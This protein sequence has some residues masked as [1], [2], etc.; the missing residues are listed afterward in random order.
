MV[1][2]PRRTR[3]SSVHLSPAASHRMEGLWCAKKEAK[4]AKEETAIVD[5]FCGRSA[6]ND[7][8]RKGEKKSKYALS[9]L[10]RR[11]SRVVRDAPIIFWTLKSREINLFFFSRCRRQSRLSVNYNCCPFFFKLFLRLSLSRSLTSNLN[12]LEIHTAPRACTYMIFIF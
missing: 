1:V 4:D 5:I 8:F 9:S 12:S 6:G 2:V 3:A 11:V 10:A 7:T